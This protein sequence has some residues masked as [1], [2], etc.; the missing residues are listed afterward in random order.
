MGKDQHVPWALTPEARAKVQQEPPEEPEPVREDEP[1]EPVLDL[2]RATRGDIRIALALSL[3]AILLVLFTYR[4]IG[5]SWDEAYYY[6]PATMAIDWLGDFLK[7]PA[8]A[9]SRQVVDWR[10]AGDLDPATNRPEGIIE[11]PSVVKWAMGVSWKLTR[12]FWAAPWNELRALRLPAALAFGLSVF[13]IYLLTLNSY[14]RR[15]AVIAA[16]AFI[17]M[18]RVFGHAHIAATETIFN[19]VVLIAIYSFFRGLNSPLWAILFGIAYG[20]ALDTKVNAVLLAP[21]LLIWGHTFHRRTYVNNFFAMVFIAPLVWVLLWPWLWQDTFARIMR[22]FLF[23]SHH[24]QTAVWYLGERWGYGNPPAPWHYPVV[25]TLLTV[26]LPMLV[27]AICGLARTSAHCR[28]EYRGILFTAYAA[29]VLIQASLPATPK[30][31]GTRLF[32][33]LFPMLAILA[34]GGADSLVTIFPFDRVLYRGIGVR[35][36]VAAL[37]VAA[38]AGNGLFAIARS[39]PHELSYFN[40]LAGGPKNLLHKYEVSYWGESLNEDVVDELNKLPPGSRIWPLA[41]HEKVLVQL[42]AWKALRDD[43]QLV[44]AP[45]FDYPLLLEQEFSVEVMNK[46]NALPE[47]TRIWPVNA[48]ALVLRRFQEQGILRKDLRIVDAPFYDYVLLHVRKGFFG[49]IETYFLSVLP[50]REFQHR[51]IPFFYLIPRPVPR[52]EAGGSTPP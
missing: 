26:P 25:M 4:G 50:K 35:H 13:L 29:V 20:V 27:L 21:V 9:A 42:Q 23:F 5:Y 49:S 12:G 30:Y 32:F 52:D 41:M 47:R 48:S 44:L 46:L 38:I 18:P 11:L 40:I 8:H 6:K 37:F 3:V 15:A 16:I 36:V 45:P 33:S 19:A 34:G 22:Y 17:A 10:W 14:R 1:R 7:D 43:L 31:D 28:W 24:Q 39:H 2:R 51:D